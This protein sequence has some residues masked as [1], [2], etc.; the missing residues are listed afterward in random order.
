MNG[1]SIAVGDFQLTVVS[2]G[3]LRNDGGTMFGVVPK[4]LWERAC[5]P[6]EQN[7]ILL[8]TN[9]LLVRTPD[10][11][12]LIDTGYGGKASPKVQ[13]RND[14]AA[15]SQLP[16]NLAAVGV[17][18]AD[19]EWV[20]LTHL[21]FD[22]AGGC[23]WRDSTGQLHPTF[24]RAKHFVQRIEW[25]DAT[26]NRPDLAGAYFPNDFVPLEEAGLVEVI[27]EVTEIAPGIATRRTD[28]HTRGHQIVTFTSRGQA[29]WYL[30]DLCP[31]VPHVRAFWSMAYDQYPL[32]V[33]TTKPA[34]LG[35]IA[36]RQDVAVFCH[37]PQC[38]FARIRR[39]VTGVSEW[40]IEPIVS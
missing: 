7:R 32:T 13:A 39:D 25:E 17:V 6:D 37:D 3:T 35:E 14:L 27:D 34:V 40:T 12:G 33:R 5:P 15:E 18:P 8:D 20:I 31:M 9:C 36:D 21:H 28:G 38:R 16:L 11:V 4:V 26:S 22:H 1:Q 2:G 30:G 23:T 10:S 29:A 24:P 19:I